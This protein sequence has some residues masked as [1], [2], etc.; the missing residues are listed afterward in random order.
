MTRRI[1]LLA[2]AA[3][4]L[5]VLSVRVAGAGAPAG[6]RAELK[7]LYT[8]SSILIEN[9]RG[10]GAV[11]RQRAALTVQADGL[12]A[13]PFSTITP[14]V[15]PPQSHLQNFPRHLLNYARVD[16]GT[17]GKVTAER[18]AFALARGTRLVILDL[19]V[20]RDSVTLFTHTAQPVRLPDGR[21]VYGCTE[22]VFH[23]DPTVIQ[24]SD[25]AAVRGVIDRWL[26][27]A[28]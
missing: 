3:T 6:L 21:V 12:P 24:R 20:K 18:G 28:A 22:F 14:Q 1:L 23:L 4:L 11:L 19:T 13:K 27:P 26:A 7:R 5:S 25:L 10:D 16:V 2:V 9:S 17:D 8:P 15:H